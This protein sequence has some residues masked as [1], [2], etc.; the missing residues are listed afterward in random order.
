MCFLAL[1][2]LLDYDAALRG[3]R[4]VSVAATSE[5]ALATQRHHAPRRLDVLRVLRCLYES[6]A[7]CG[8]GT[9]ISCGVRR[10]LRLLSTAHCAGSVVCRGALSFWLAS[11]RAYIVAFLVINVEAVRHLNLG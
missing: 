6:T 1:R 2:Q 11:T 5:D 8:L 3:E 7:G 9:L 4:Q 10:L